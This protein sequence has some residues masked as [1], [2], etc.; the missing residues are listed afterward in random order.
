MV[1]AGGAF[2]ALFVVACATSPTEQLE[3]AEVLLAQLESRGAE[4]YLKYEL[5][6]ARRK[7]EEARKF[8]RKNQFEVASQYLYHV[9]RTLDSCGVAFLQ[10]RQLAQQQCR[11]QVSALDA[12]M[13]SLRNLVVK[14]PR[15]SYIDQNR[16]DIY[17]HRLRRYEDEIN[18]LQKLIAQEEFPTALQRSAKLGFQVKQSLAGITS[19]KGATEGP[20]TVA[21]S[22]SVSNEAKRPMVAATS[23]SSMR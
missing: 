2:L 21:T 4:A 12:E 6:T 14:L 9:C 18:I 7:L 15:Q 22:P 5:A 11:Q 19:I 8:I 16:Y 10:L 17:M 1:G 20:T 23:Q 3:R 13:Q